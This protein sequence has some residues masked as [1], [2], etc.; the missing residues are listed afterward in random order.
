MVSVTCQSPL[1][2]LPK[3][4]LLRTGNISTKEAEEILLQS[5]QSITE[6]DQKD[7]GLLEILQP[8][9]S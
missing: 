3:I 6:L 7:L 8:V 4:V 5:K 2:Y 9:S 1:R